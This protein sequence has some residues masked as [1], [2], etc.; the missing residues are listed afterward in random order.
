MFVMLTTRTVR[1][2]Q[3]KRFRE[4]DGPTASLALAYGSVWYLISTFITSLRLGFEASRV[5]RHISLPSCEDSTVLPQRHIVP[6]I[7]SLPKCTQATKIPSK[8][9]LYSFRRDRDISFSQSPTTKYASN[10][11]RCHCF[12][13]AIDSFRVGRW[14]VSSIIHFPRSYSWNT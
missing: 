11:V 1:Y 4:P 14:R 8:S 13:Y 12:E 10:L 5:H 2:E 9:P 3:L 6:I 7:S